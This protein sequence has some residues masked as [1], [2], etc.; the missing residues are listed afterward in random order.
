MLKLTAPG[1]QLNDEKDARPSVRHT[2]RCDLGFMDGHCEHPQL[3]Q[4]YIGQTPT[5]RWFLP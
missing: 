1:S 5:N 2:G 4:F 3:K